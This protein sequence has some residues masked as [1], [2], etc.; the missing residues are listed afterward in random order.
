MISANLSSLL[1]TCAQLMAT[2]RENRGLNFFSLRGEL[3]RAQPDCI[4]Y[5]ATQLERA[6]NGQLS[7][8]ETCYILVK[9]APMGTGNLFLAVCSALTPAGV[10]SSPTS[11]MAP[12]VISP[13]RGLGCAKTEWVRES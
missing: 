13:G 3:Y 2:G 8:R 4:A 5:L 7:V 9:D 6:S 12:Y 10:V 11:D 1:D